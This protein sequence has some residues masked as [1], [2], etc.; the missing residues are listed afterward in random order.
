MLWILWFVWCGDLLRR[1]VV[2]NRIEGRLM[3][4]IRRSSLLGK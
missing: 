3:I 4:E 2:G 1:L